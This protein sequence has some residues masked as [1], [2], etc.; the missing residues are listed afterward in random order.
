MRLSSHIETR[1]RIGGIAFTTIEMVMATTIFMMI[2]IA[3]VAGEIYG[4]RVYTLAATK[5][6]A[7]DSARHTLD[8]LRETIQSA[9]GILDVGNYTWASGSPTNFAVIPSGTQQIGN[10]IRIQAGANTVFSLT[11]PYTLV[12]LQPENGGT[13][14]ATTGPTGNLINTNA[15]IM[16]GFDTN[17]NPVFTNILGSYITNQ[18][19]FTATD[20]TGTNIMTNN[21][22]NRVIQIT[23]FFSQWEYPIAI[24][25]SNDI[26][27][28]NYYRLQTRVTRRAL[29][30]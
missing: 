28:Y 8:M 2:I 5:L 30:D 13:N 22:N 17:Y 7:T 18:A 27:A 9:N 4:T 26:N 16:E 29:N 23:L 11:A 24:I 20:Y 3:L 10:A 6:S 25:G 21:V 19:V 12:F 1:S 14:F 15:L